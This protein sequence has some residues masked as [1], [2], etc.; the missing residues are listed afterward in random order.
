M[1]EPCKFLLQRYCH[2]AQLKSSV[3]GVDPETTFVIL[4][5][6]LFISRIDTL[7][8]ISYKKISIGREFSSKLNCLFS[9]PRIHIDS[10]YNIPL[11]YC[12]GFCGTNY[13]FRSGVS[14]RNEC[15][16]V[17]INTGHSIRSF[18]VVV[19]VSPFEIATRA[20]L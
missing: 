16:T 6:L 1:K 2:R 19:T 7:R 20:E 5:I 18:R 15:G 17:T 11:F 14:S 4:V 12:N 8:T 10:Y 13:R 3:L 9:Y